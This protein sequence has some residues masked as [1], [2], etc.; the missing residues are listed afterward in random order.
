MRWELDRSED[1]A[2]WWVRDAL[3]TIQPRTP[4]SDSV[5]TP[6][7]DEATMYVCEEMAI[8]GGRGFNPRTVN[9]YTYLS[10]IPI[11]DEATIHERL[12]RFLAGLEANA[13]NLDEN[14]RAFGAEQ[15]VERRHWAQADLDT[16]NLLALLEH[17]R[18]VLLTLDRFFKLHFKLVFPRHAIMAQFEEVAQE[19]AGL[20]SDADVG[21]LV[22]AMG[23]TKQLEFDAELWR[24]AA[25]AIDAGL[26]D[27]LLGTLEA[28]LP[29][30]L[31]GS[32]A[33]RAWL[34]ELGRF[35]D[36]FGHRM[37]LPME[38]HDP[39]WCEDITPVL[40]T[41]RTYVAEGGEYDFDGLLARLA[42]EQRAFTEQTIAAI[43][44]G[45]GRDRFTGML[46]P[47]R[48]LQSASEDDN[49][50]LFWSYAQV[51][52]VALA[53]GRR[54]AEGGVVADADDVFFLTKQE[55]E[56]A[57]VDLATGGLY[58]TSSWSGLVASRREEWAQQARTVP[59][60]YIGDLPDEVH[61]LLLNRFWGITG[62]RQLDDGQRAELTGVG[63]SGGIAEGVARVVVTPAD[64]GR[65]EPGEILVCASTN[66]A[67]TPLFSKI[68]GVVAD[69]GGSLS[70]AAIVAR[71]YGIP[72]VLGTGHAT[73][74][75]ADGAR[76]RID[77]QRGTVEFL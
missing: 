51:R 75:I 47:V 19:V 41:I 10:P 45:E 32:E 28:D 63:A 37:T 64:F 30:V 73:A 4:L 7:W 54:L 35:L 20:D 71:E 21:K 34:A 8:P 76:L 11:T 61:D 43:E 46:D 62:R 38:L 18:R 24:L 59:P 66:P 68:A 3:Y 6:A 25:A 77:G 42:E 17:W 13:A 16:T 70:H 65:V 60:P 5:F 56:G 31:E 58:D 12:G 48:R 39:T 22:Q 67:W 1:K 49:I 9:G 14:V 53:V 2:R 55:L 27:E 57:L 52:R 50:N 44:P 36:E 23:M 74:R 26:T 29:G 69:Q 72:A 15:E 40:G 33:G